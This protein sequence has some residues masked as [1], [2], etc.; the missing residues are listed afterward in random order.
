[1]DF[2]EILQ[3]KRKLKAE[4][5]ELQAEV[6][7]LEQLITDY[8]TY[9]AGIELVS[10]NWVLEEINYNKIILKSVQVQSYFE[11]VS[12]ENI[13]GRLLPTI[14]AINSAKETTVTICSAIPG[15]VNLINDKI[16]ELKKQIEAL[17]AELTALG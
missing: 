6:K 2:F 11:G 5:R 3:K 14:T 12:A 15:Q 4:I 7:E 8:N 1:M 13:K 9:R 17:E 10:S 16:T